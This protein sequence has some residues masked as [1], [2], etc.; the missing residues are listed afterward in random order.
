MPE[1]TH[2]LRYHLSKAAGEAVDAALLYNHIAGHT[3]VNARELVEH[4]RANIKQ[5]VYVNMRGGDDAAA[6]KACIVAASF[7][8]RAAVWLRRSK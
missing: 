5:G 7:S 6:A 2:A 1:P 4:G 8:L 3:V